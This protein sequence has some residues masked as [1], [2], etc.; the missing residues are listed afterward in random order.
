MRAVYERGLTV[1]IPHSVDLW[2]Y[3]CTF[4]AEK[5]DD[6]DDIRGYVELI[7][8][9]SHRRLFERGLSIVSLDFA[10]HPLWD[11]YIE[12]ENSQVRHCAIQNIMFCLHFRKSTKGLVI[13]IT[14]S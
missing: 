13:S 1:G 4:V 11:K 14:E 6:L 7:D 9:F 2:A 3:Y 8:Q 12:F 10:S 5:S